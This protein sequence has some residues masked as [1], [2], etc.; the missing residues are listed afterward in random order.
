MIC[1]PALAVSLCLFA[2]T[3]YGASTAA[4]DAAFLSALKT[5][6]AKQGVVGPAGPVGPKGATGAT[7]PAG[8]Q[9]IQGIPGPAGPQGPIG[10]AGPTGPQGPPGP[11]GGTVPPPVVS[12]PAANGQTWSLASNNS[13]WGAYPVVGGQLGSPQGPYWVYDNIWGVDTSTTTFTQSFSGDAGA[14]PCGITIAWSYPQ[15]PAPSGKYAYPELIYGGTPYKIPASGSIATKANAFQTLTLAWNHTIGGEL[16]H[17]DTI[18]DIW[19]TGTCGGGASDRQFEIMLFTHTDVQNGVPWNARTS[20]PGNYKF[21]ATDASYGNYD[22]T[23]LNYGWK[24]IA[25]QPPDAGDRLNNSF[26]VKAMLQQLISHGVITGTE[27]VTGIEFGA[28]PDQG[29]GSMTISSYAVNW[30]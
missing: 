16:G 14:F 9:G 13:W 26:D 11:S 6:V 18:F 19:G 24:G 1:K 25:I 10:P 15:T 2:G 22:V 21:S 3:A 23:V 7:G 5:W 17:Y 29:S 20:N 12:C 27:C 28:E 30:K 4:D 8:P